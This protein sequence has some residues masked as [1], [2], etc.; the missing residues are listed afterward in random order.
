M[1]NTSLRNILLCLLAWSSQVSLG[2]DVETHS[3]VKVCNPAETF[4]TNV[5]ANLGLHVNL[6]D[7]AGSEFGTVGNPIFT[8]GSISSTVGSYTDRGAFSYSVD[9]FN[10]TGGIYQDTGA[11]LTAGQVGV[12]RMTQSR[13]IHVNLRDAS[14]TEFATVTNPLVT[15]PSNAYG[16]FI[17]GDVTTA[18]TTLARVQR[19]AY[20]EQ[21]TDAQRSIASSSASDT[22][23]GTGARQVKISYCTAAFVCGLTDTITLNGVSFVNTAATNI[24]YIEKW[25]VVAVGSGLANIG[26]LTFK[27]AV[28]GGG[29]TIGTIAAG[30]NQTFWSHHYVPTGKTCNIT[31]FSVSHNGT[32]VG[33]GGVFHVRAKNLASATAVEAQISD[34]IRAYGQSSGT[35]RNYGSPIKVIGPSRISVFVLPESSTS[36]VFRGSL[37]FYEL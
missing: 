31:G 18:A 34:F 16:S 19:T 15:S 22:A 11:T 32:T 7:A 20:I 13:G 3:K 37:D 12:S 6:R 14:G 33:S 28:A 26:T 2:A 23:A 9:K 27:A 21:T 30:E 35:T 8:S 17:F 36:T 10:P 29:V 25:E 1:R 5:T 4:C 24:A